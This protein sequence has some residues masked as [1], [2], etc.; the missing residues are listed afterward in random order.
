MK[1]KVAKRILALAMTAAFTVTAVP[2]PVHTVEAE[3][4]GVLR[5]W[6]SQPASEGTNILSPGAYGTTAEDN[7]WQQQTLPIGNSYMGANVY[8]EIAEERL[9]FNHKTLWNGG[10]STRRPDYNGGNKETTASGEK[11]SDLYKR[12]MELYKE[13]KDT[14]ANN[15]SSQLVGIIDGY[16]AYQ[17]WGDIYL[18]FGFDESTAENYVRDLNLENAVAS[19][20]FDYNGTKMHREYF[21]SHPDNVLAMKFTAEG[22]E[23]LNFDISFPIDNAEGVT[24]RNLGKTVNTT[25]EE[26]TITVAG[27]MQDNQMKLNGQLKVVPKDGSVNAKDAQSL[28]VAD[29]TEVIIYVSAD[30]DYANEYPVY[31]TGESAEELDASVEADIAAAA[32]KGYE[33]VKEA[34]IADHSGIFSRVDLDLGQNVPKKATDVLLAGYKN[35]SNTAE[36]DRALEVLLFQYGRYLTIASSREGDLPSNLQ[37]VWQNRV[38]DHNRVPWGSD[39]H[40]N[41]NLQ[42]NYW[43]TYSTNMAECAVPIVDYVYSLMEPGKIT[44]KTYFGV[45]N[46]GFTAHTQNTP[47]GWTC[48][49]WSFSWGW[50]PAALPWILQNC[51]EYYEYTG[52]VE[53]MRENI[54]PM[55]KESALLYDQIMI[56]DPK[57]GRLVSAPAYS[58][59]HGPITAGNTYEQSLIWQLYEDASIAAG[60]LGVDEDLVANW[61]ERQARLMP[62]EIGD[63]GQIKEWYTE[64][65]LGSLGASGH[66]HMSHLLGLFP[67]DLISVDNSEYM[68]A[69]IVSLRERGDKSTGWGMGQRINSWA[70]TGDGNQAHKL[71]KTLFNDGI[72]PNLWDS[73]APFQIDGNFGMTAGV[74]EM[75]LQS[76]MG[77]IN[78]LPALPDVWATGS[79]DGLIARGNFEVSMDWEDKNLT[80]ATILSKNGGTA[81]VQTTNAALATVTDSKGNVMDIE[82]LS[83]DRIAF[84]TEAGETYTLKDIPAANNIEVPPGLSASRIK[85]ESVELTWDAMEGVTYNVYRQVG[86]G[87]VQRIASG[88][89]EAAYEDM[90]ASD[91][92]GDIQYQISASVDRGESKKSDKASVKDLRNMAGIIDNADSRVVYEG[93]GWG[94][95]TAKEGNYNDTIQYINNADV[96]GGETATLEFVGTGIQVMTCTQW[97]RGF[98]EVF[99]DGESYGRLNT[100]SASQK[101]QSIVFTEDGLEYGRH[102]I[103][104]KVLNEKVAESSG[105]KVELDAFVVLDNTAAQPERINVSTV[106]GIT[107]AAEAGSQV[108]MKAEVLPKEV[109][110]KTVTWSSS[111]TSLA[112]VDEN[113]L[114]TIGSQ[115]GTVTITATSTVNTSVSGSAELKIAIAG[116]AQPA[117]T[118]VED[119]NMNSTKND[120][121]TW[122][123]NWSTWAGEA[124]RH[125]G[126]TKTECNG[127]GNYFEYS[128]NGTGIEVYVQKHANFAALE[129]FIDGESQGVK[130]MNGSGSG[131]DQQLLFSKKD[132]E[133]GQHTIR[134]VIVEERGKNQANLDYLKIF[135]PTESTEVDK[136][137]LQ[138]NITMASKLVETAYAPE[139]WQAFKAVYNRAVQVMNDDDATEAQVENAVNELAEAVIAL[140]DAQA[141]MITD[142]TAEAILVE[143]TRVMLTWD[144]VE[145]AVSY[146]IKAGELVVET[147]DTSCIVEGLASGTTYR[148]EIYA[149]NEGGESASAIELEVTTALS[150]DEAAIAPVT[151]IQKEVTGADSVRLSWTA[152][153]DAA[154]YAVYMG[155]QKLGETESAEYELT[156]LEAGKPYV[157]KVVAYDAEG[158]QSLPAQFTFVMEGKTPEPS[159]SDK[160][161]LDA[162]IEYAQGQ[163]GSEEYQLLV[164]AVKNAFEAALAEAERVSADTA[165]TQEEVDAAYDALLTKVHLLGFIGGS[166]DDLE[167]LYKILSELNKDL[168]TEESIEVLEAALK[169]AQEVLADGENA[170]KVDIDNAMK[171][172]EE[173]QAGLERLP[174]DKTKL[175]ALIAQGEGYLAEAEKYLSVEDLQTSLASAKEVYGRDDVTQEEINTAYGVLLQSI[176]GLR[177]V[178][179]KEALKDLIKAVE[180][181]DLSEYSDASAKAVKAALAAAI[182]AYEDD[183]ADQKEVDAAAEALNAAVEALKTSSDETADRSDDSDKDG[184]NESGSKVASDNGK[185]TTG[186]TTGN[187]TGK[188]AAK[189]GDA[190]NVAIPA[191]AGLM[192]VLAAIA[193]WRKRTNA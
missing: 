86:D 12:I 92:L 19:V 130:S 13:G 85:A 39:Y 55:L 116:D 96:V 107:T 153:D 81:T 104:L 144:A 91:R 28:S 88:L 36:E 26:N 111:N 62:I 183:T 41:V 122:S 66:R 42:M 47:F 29:A 177:E 147:T 154:G 95:W 138:R 135:T 58:P 162:L 156:G 125:H 187:T 52:D 191:A 32:A 121:I 119:G 128:F 108:Q 33:A 149:V 151:D 49:G 84:E 192:A 54:Y 53:F 99:I 117:E 87:E 11:M 71:I 179:N 94:N 102:T 118:I 148:F 6:Y 109:F 35:G 63:S 93:S 159:E 2:F 65:T 57:T 186:K 133:N 105:V 123:G 143:S 137:E 4:G 106:S 113:G 170:L 70:R 74:A 126:G 166:T 100:Y 24:S 160:S 37:G 14:E 176:F 139:K 124:D 101:R 155:G 75:L 51:W 5:L 76:N 1:T 98:Y 140:G 34:H 22:N 114:V 169:L 43:P 190:A 60:I 157:V 120:A 79:V 25:V 40:M 193:A 141:P 72:Y 115:N 77:Y 46:G 56:E 168:Y 61:R 161:D 189:T 9:T 103:V 167:Q 90:T 152:S 89:T 78:M 83:A 18:D 20:D 180:A 178:P 69:A 45:E 132:L 172:L 15:L 174:F 110:D 3:E 38:G 164:P 50:S 67:G 136:A 97:D 68:E 17:S 23:K 48:P 182:A 127:A 73:H 134:C 16:G 184:S 185:Q 112:T 44:A 188:S 7:T 80:E 129:V 8:G 59:E 82:V 150:K 30:T 175:A 163:K 10:P 146:K 171:A 158:N 181:M 31:R 145:G 173:A 64:T 131:D 27:E 165:A 21:M 142:E